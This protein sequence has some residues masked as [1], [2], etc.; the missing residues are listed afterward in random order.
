MRLYVGNLSYT[1]TE[2]TLREAF[3]NYGDVISV[4]IM[5]DKFT[6]ASRGFGFIEMGTEIQSERAIGGMNGKSVDGRRIR[7]SE[8]VDRPDYV[9]EAKKFVRKD[10]DEE[11]F[12]EDR[13]FTERKRFPARRGEKYG[14]FERGERGGRFEKSERRGFRPAERK[15]SSAE[16]Y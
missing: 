8:A 12:G 15:E 2:E 6:E 4:L 9:N 5:K 10:G 13:N 1:T 3:S 16:E 14:R 7:V 11:T